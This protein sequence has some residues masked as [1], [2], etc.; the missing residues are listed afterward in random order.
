VHQVKYHAVRDRIHDLIDGLAVGDA[1]PAER[2]LATDLGVSRMTLRRAIDELVASGLV[3]RRHGAGTFVAA[4]KIAQPLAG[5][6]FSEDM[7]RR[8]LTPA[9]RTITVEEIHAGPQLGRRLEVSPATPVLR[10]V[11]QRSADAAPMAIETLHV[12]VTVV[13]DLT[14]ED[15]TDASFYE[16]LAARGIQLDR[17]VQTIEPTVTDDEESELLGIPLH[18]PAFLF[19]RTSRDADGRIVEFVRSVYRGDR[20]KLT[21]ELQAAPAIVP[22][23]GAVSSDGG[24]GNVSSD[25]GRGNVSSDGG[26]GNVS[27]DGR[28]DLIGGQA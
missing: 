26:R 3:E 10:I 13:P 18:S 28:R 14:P 24:R 19:E 16:L 2:T 27:S 1:L 8:G 7:R 4:P 5:T 12:P 21:A 11:R 22:P 20:Y 25:G 9:S 15:L 17:A 23:R 6:S